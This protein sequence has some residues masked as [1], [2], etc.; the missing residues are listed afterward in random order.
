MRDEERTMLV[1]SID[2]FNE[3]LRLNAYYIV[4]GVIS[5]LVMIFLPLIGSTISLDWNLPDTEAGWIVFIICRL[6]VSG[7]NIV[8]FTSFVEQ[9][10]VN[11]ANNENYKKANEILGKV[12]KNKEYKIVSPKEFFNG[13][14]FKKGITI[15]ITTLGAL[16][17]FSQAVFTYSWQDLV[18]YGFC[19]IIAIV[20]GIMTMI[21]VEIYLT[22]EY[23][24][25]AESTKENKD[26][27]R[28]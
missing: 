5:L 28:S 13:I 16:F 3:K 21:K 17:A 11:V 8:I 12:K 18:T 1:S 2:D 26:D 20:F 19:V 7:L 9:A 25:Y 15:F 23:L 24:L 22:T 10:K 6:I 14:Y 27:S 4:I